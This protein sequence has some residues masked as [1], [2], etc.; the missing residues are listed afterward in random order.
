MIPAGEDK[1][2]NDIRSFRVKSCYNG[3]RKS[4]NTDNEQWDSGFESHYRL[5]LCFMSCV[6]R[7]FAMSKKPNQTSKI[8]IVTQP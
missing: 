3:Y 8:F 7:G 4:V 6:G 2:G 1:T 5:F